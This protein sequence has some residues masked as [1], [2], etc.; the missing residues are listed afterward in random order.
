VSVT[1]FSQILA[2]AIEAVGAVDREGFDAAAAFARDAVAAAGDG[3]LTA[4]QS[5]AACGLEPAVRLSFGIENL[6]EVRKQ[7]DARKVDDVTLTLMKVT[8][9][10][11]CTVKALAQYRSDRTATGLSA[12]TLSGRTAAHIIGTRH[13]ATVTRDLRL[14]RQASAPTSRIRLRADR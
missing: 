5:L 2:A 6:G 12:G 7:F 13:Q 3:H 14:A 8:L 10:Q 1:S 9:L 4:A 11:M